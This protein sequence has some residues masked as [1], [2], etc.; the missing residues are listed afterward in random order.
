MEKMFTNLKTFQGKINVDD[1]CWKRNVL[2]TTIRCW[3]SIS[4][5]FILPSGTNIDKMPP[6]LSHQH[7]CH[8]YVTCIDDIKLGT[9]AEVNEKGKHLNLELSRVWLSVFKALSVALNH[10][11][12][13]VKILSLGNI[14]F[15][16]TFFILALLAIGSDER[17][18][19]E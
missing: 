13:P 8:L 12:F 6:T 19:K 10:W 7:S 5:I 15:I 4:A 17:N 3:W 2:V 18:Y 9:V 14:T 1:G 11:E 16:S